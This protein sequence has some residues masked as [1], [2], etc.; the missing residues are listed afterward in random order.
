[1]IDIQY[2]ELMEQVQRGAFLTVETP[3]GLNTMTIGWFELG[4]FWRREVMTV[5]VRPSRHTFALM[6]GASHYSVTVPRPKQFAK[7]LAFCG[8]ESGRDH[9]K[10]AVCSLPLQYHEE[11]HI[12]YVAIPGDHLFGKIVNTSVMEKDHTDRSLDKHYPQGDYHTLYTAEI[13]HHL[14]LQ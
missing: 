3:T 9:D 1:M 4:F 14:K 8:T 2:A 13:I 5:G 7:E 12:P 11:G 6:E 10:F